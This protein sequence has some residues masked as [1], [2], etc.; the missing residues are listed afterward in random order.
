MKHTAQTYDY[1][2][3]I[4]LRVFSVKLG[5]DCTHSRS[6][7]YFNGRGYKKINAFKEFL[8]LSNIP[9]Q[10]LSYNATSTNFNDKMID[11]STDDMVE[12]ANIFRSF[13]KEIELPDS[14]TVD[15]N[16][17]T[18]SIPK[19]ELVYHTRIYN[20][21]VNIEEFEFH[22]TRCPVTLRIYYNYN[23]ATIIRMCFDIN[24]AFLRY[25]KIDKILQA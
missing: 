25:I 2:K 20:N 24:V 22:W 10:E 17:I 1:T 19:T 8:T 23:N 3:Y 16:D 4:L 5:G 15:Y 11:V 6:G 18:Y 13:V 7:I 14:L 21:L 9:F 12:L